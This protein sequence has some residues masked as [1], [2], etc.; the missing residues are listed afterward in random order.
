MKK[1]IHIAKNIKPELT[2]EACH[3]ISEEYAKLR[4]ID[5]ESDI[6]KVI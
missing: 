3:V 4:T 5:T 2:E 1:Y 6:A